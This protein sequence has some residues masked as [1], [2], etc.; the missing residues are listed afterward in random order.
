ML[1]GRFWHCFLSI[2]GSLVGVS[3]LFCVS[4]RLVSSLL[5]ASSRGLSP[6]SLT[7]SFVRVLRNERILCILLK[8]VILFSSCLKLLSTIALLALDIV[9]LV[10]ICLLI[11]MI[12]W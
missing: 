3:H 5:S 1:T 2:I 6:M 4:L 11:M 10:V 9:V 8:T 12:F 7:T